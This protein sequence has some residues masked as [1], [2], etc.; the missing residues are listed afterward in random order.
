MADKSKENEDNGCESHNWAKRRQKKQ[1]GVKEDKQDTINI[2]EKTWKVELRVT[3][4]RANFEEEWAKISKTKNKKN[5]RTKLKEIAAITIWCN[6][7]K[8][9]TKDTKY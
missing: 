1:T 4:Y 3:Q 7:T 8:E 2:D 9:G 5:S 6:Q